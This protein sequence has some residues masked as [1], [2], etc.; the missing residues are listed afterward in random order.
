M[1]SSSSKQWIQTKDYSLVLSR[2]ALTKIARNRWY[3]ANDKKSPA[4]PM[5]AMNDEDIPQSDKRHQ[6]KSC[7]EHDGNQD[8]HE[9]H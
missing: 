8:E 1:E 7:D 3:D 5:L 9:A 6:P 2:F 4:P